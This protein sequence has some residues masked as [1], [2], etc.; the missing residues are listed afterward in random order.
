[1]IICIDRYVYIDRYRYRYRYSYVVTDNQFEHQLYIDI[2]VG[3]VPA[4]H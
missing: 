2:H 1:M 3:L 4:I